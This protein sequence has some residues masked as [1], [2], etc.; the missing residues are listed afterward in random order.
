MT[1]LSNT[2]VFTGKLQIHWMNE[3][4]GL[5]IQQPTERQICS[6]FAGKRAMFQPQLEAKKLSQNSSELW[7]DVFKGHVI[8]KD[9]LS[10][11]LLKR[12]CFHTLN[13]EEWILPLYSYTKITW[14]FVWWWCSWRS[15]PQKTF[16]P[17]ARFFPQTIQ[18]LM[19]WLKKTYLQKRIAKRI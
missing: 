9:G 18:W 16:T 10:T 19:V 13:Q 15:L 12:K 6:N 5:W 1:F 14:W 3:I 7:H 17:A 4:L 11:F 8:K 2:N